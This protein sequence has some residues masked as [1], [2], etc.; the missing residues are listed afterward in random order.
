MRQHMLAAIDE[1]I[2]A[3]KEELSV[4]TGKEWICSRARVS[5]IVTLDLKVIE[6]MLELYVNA[7]ELLLERFENVRIKK[8]SDQRSAIG[9]FLHETETFKQKLEKLKEDIVT[10]SEA[11]N[12]RFTDGGSGLNKEITR[13]WAL[14]LKEI[15]GYIV[16][17]K[18]EL[19]PLR[20]YY[21]HNV[22]DVTH[23][24]LIIW[25]E[26]EKRTAM[27]EEIKNNSWSLFKP[28]KSTSI[29]KAEQFA[30]DVEKELAWLRQDTEYEFKKLQDEIKSLN[31]RGV[32][33]ESKTPMYRLWVA[34]LADIKIAEDE[35]RK[36]RSDVIALK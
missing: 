5:G 24:M 8:K 26:M 29:A 4:L 3:C 6:Q 30:D 12:K 25:K 32:S 18:S 11:Y 21:N 20:V 36:F 34:A 9:K 13:K 17:V 31:K 1:Q 7:W 22:T 2:F 33:P 35:I 27:L 14:A 28:H 10:G 19:S 15:E 16:T 23:D